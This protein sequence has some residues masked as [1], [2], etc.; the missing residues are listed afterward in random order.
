MRYI[1]LII[2]VCGATPA[3]AVVN[4]TE[5]AESLVIAEMAEKD[6]ASKAVKTSKKE[7]T[8]KYYKV[9]EET[10]TVEA[11]LNVF[12][13]K[14]KSSSL[15]RKNFWLYNTLQDDN[16]SYLSFTTNDQNA[17]IVFSP[18]EEFVY[19]IEITPDGERRLNGVKI[20]TQEEFFI[21]TADSFFIQ[22]CAGGQTS[23]VIVTDDASTYHV[24]DLNGEAVA[25]PDA[26]S[27]IDDLKNVICN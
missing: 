1:L 16:A 20:S 3:W 5:V 12:K 6:Q 4:S 23:Y 10:D 27:N 8:S 26:L 25:L 24:F 19:Y 9:K 22:T 13:K 14:G 17:G 15:Y 2:F 11:A 18:D 7:Y 21:N